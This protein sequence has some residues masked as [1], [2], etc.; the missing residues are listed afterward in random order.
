MREFVVGQNLGRWRELGDL[1]L[2]RDLAGAQ[3]RFPL[4]VIPTFPSEHQQVFVANT[5]KAE[6]QTAV[7][8][9]G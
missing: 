5:M 3:S 6:R 9:G 4:R 1:V 2:Q 8:A 7:S